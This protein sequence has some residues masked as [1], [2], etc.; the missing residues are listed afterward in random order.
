MGVLNPVVANFGLT[1]GQVQQVYQ[2]PADK[3]YAVIDVLLFK[4]DI[5]QDSLVE[6]ALTTQSNPGSL[7]SV[8]YF[9]DDISLVGTANTAELNKIIVGPGERLYIKTISG[10]TVNARITGVEENNT[11]VVKAGRLAAASVATTTQTLVYQN[12]ISNVAYISTSLTLFN[13]STTNSATFEVWAT[14]SASPID[15]DKILNVSVSPQDTC[16]IENIMLAPTESIYFRSN[17]PSAEYFLNGLVV[18]S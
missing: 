15:S 7:T 16:I 6:I 14:R 10:P 9:I 17:Q 11:K 2:C 4:N 13:T 18:L 8:D 5:T 3:S 12:A 1:T